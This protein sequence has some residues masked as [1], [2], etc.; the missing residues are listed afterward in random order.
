M[1]ALADEMAFIAATLSYP[2]CTFVTKVFHEFDFISGPVEGEI[3]IIEA[4]ILGKGRS[5]IHV[6]VRASNA[7]T[8]RDIFKTEAVLVNAKDGKSVPIPDQPKPAAQ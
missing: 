8:K 6:S 7:V 4:E 5:S 2:C 1:M 3:V